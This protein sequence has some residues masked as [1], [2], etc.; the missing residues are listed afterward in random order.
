MATEDETTSRPGPLGDVTMPGVEGVQA[1]ADDTSAA[2][3]TPVGAAEPPGRARSGPD[4][5]GS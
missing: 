5:L 3:L 4:S 2:A 1:A